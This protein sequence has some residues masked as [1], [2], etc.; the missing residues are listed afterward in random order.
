MGLFSRIMGGARRV[1][2]AI[3]S[4]FGMGPKVPVTV[5]VHAYFA[6]RG[7][8]LDLAGTSE[9]VIGMAYLDLPGEIGHMGIAFQKHVRQKSGALVPSHYPP[10][11]YIYRVP[12]E[13]YEAAVGSAS[14]GHWVWTDIRWAGI[15]HDGPY[16]Y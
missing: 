12:R 13:K 7:N 10:V 6:N 2:S 5:D 4:L 15:T 9:H 14:R 8:W 16:P 11:Y 1:A 3:G